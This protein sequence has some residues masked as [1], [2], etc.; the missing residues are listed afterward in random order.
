MSQ[1]EAYPYIVSEAQMMGMFIGIW[2]VLPIVTFM[3]KWLSFMEYWWVVSSFIY[4][5]LVYD[6]QVLEKTILQKKIGDPVFIF[7]V[8]YVAVVA[9]GVLFLLPIYIYGIR[10]AILNKKI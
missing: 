8:I 6:A 9:A 2:L 3:L 10:R 4:G 5:F 7:L 1:Q